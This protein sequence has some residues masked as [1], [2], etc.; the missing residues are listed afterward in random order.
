MDKTEGR[1]SLIVEDLPTLSV[2]GEAESV[3]QDAFRK[4]NSFASDLW[5]ESIA[6]R[7]KKKSRLKTVVA[8]VS[9]GLIS[10]FIFLYLSFPFNVVREVFV[11]RINE[12]MIQSQLPLRLTLGRIGPVFPVGVSLENLEITNIN[13]P[14]AKL[15]IK[16]AEVSPS[17]LSLFTGSLSLSIDIEQAGGS[18]DVEFTS[19][20]SGL[21]KSLNSRSFRLPPAEVAIQLKSFQIQPFIAGFLGY[22]RSSNNPA[23][24]T[25]ESLLQTDVSGLLSGKIR[26]INPEPGDSVDNMTVDVEIDIAKGAFEIT[27]ENLAIPR[28]TFTEAKLYAKLRK[29]IFT[30]SEKT[31][32]NANDIKLALSGDLKLSDNLDV[33]DIK[34]KMSLKLLGRFKENFD[35]TLPVGIGCSPAKMVEGEMDVEFSGVIGAMTCT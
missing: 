19:G 20:I 2:V 33:T 28:Q 21:T 35:F 5:V 8:Y 12:S 10:F 7:T 27:D 1:S 13:V 29:K 4:D 11:S 14:E 3:T 25:F 6:P 9:V 26:A 32:F 31:K 22:V 30:I 17:L 34:L 18:L 15:K 24:K 23:V 16:S